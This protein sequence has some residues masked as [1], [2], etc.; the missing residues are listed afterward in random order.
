[1]ASLPMLLN[2]LLPLVGEVFPRRGCGVA[3]EAWVEYCESEGLESSVYL[4]GNA[5]LERE[6]EV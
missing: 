6:A 5:V 4:A 3:G 1:M 2:R